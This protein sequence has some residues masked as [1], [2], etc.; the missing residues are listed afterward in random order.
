M[1]D[2]KKADTK[3]PVTFI[4]LGMMG[5]HM[6]GHILSAGHPLHVQSD[7]RQGQGA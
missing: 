1:T 7:P 3:A 5:A 2:A 6:A 4:G